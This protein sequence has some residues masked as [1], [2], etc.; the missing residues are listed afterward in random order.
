MADDKVNEVGL[1]PTLV[2]MT[3]ALRGTDSARAANRTVYG[4]G[5]WAFYGQ[6]EG[7]AVP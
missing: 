6:L 7:I 5:R 2:G 3:A 4:Y 1:F